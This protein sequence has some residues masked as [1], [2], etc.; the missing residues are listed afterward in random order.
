A[1]V[2]PVSL[3]CSPPSGTQLSLGSTMVSC[4]AVDGGGS[5]TNATFFAH[6]V[7]TTAPVIVVPAALTTDAVSPLGVTVSFNAHATD[8]VDGTDPVVCGPLASGAVFPAGDTLVTCTAT[9]AAG[10]TAASGFVVH[11]RGAAEQLNS[12]IADVRAA[13]QT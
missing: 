13:T 3:S 4:Q 6:V 11:V 12:L 9:D 1:G 5:V 7:D 8:I 2:Q 10:N